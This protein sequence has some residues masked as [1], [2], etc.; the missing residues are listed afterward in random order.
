MARK[1]KPV[2]KCHLCGGITQLTFEHVPPKK[3]FNARPQRIYR[4][5]ELVKTIIHPSP[6]WE[7]SGLKYT[8]KQRGMGEYTLCQRCNNNTGDW[9]A[10]SFIDLVY[11]GARFVNNT[12]PDNLHNGDTHEV[13]FHEIFPLR[14]VKQVFTMFCSINNPEF[15]ENHP[16]I[17]G[18][19]LNRSVRGLDST[20]YALLIHIGIG[21]LVRNHGSAGILNFES[22]QS[23][24]ISEL[25]APPF[26]FVLEFNPSEEVQLQSNNIISLTNQFGYDEQGDVHVK[27][28]VRATNTMFPGDYRGKQEILD[29]R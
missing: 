11:Q 17:R 5:D 22:G 6:P 26:G 7:F 23:R 21:E 15:A 13:L 25:S 20:S 4:G 8:Q 12:G 19:I 14:V 29:A 18:F 1:N 28:P 27:I 10:T 24:I 2:G 9:Y 16:D 3:A